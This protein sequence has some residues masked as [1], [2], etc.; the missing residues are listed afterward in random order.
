MA[1]A[2]STYHLKIVTPDRLFFDGD[3]ENII[4]PAVDGDVGILKGHINYVTPLSTGVL[5]LRENGDWKIAALSGGFLKVEKSGTVI[6][7]NTCEWKEEIDVE[8]ARRA[9][10]KARDILNAKESEKRTRYAEQNLKKALNRI[11]IA[12]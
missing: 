6:V 9:E 2:E 10:Q 11:N 1:E 12:T 3:V 8:R 7:A 4:V 5:R